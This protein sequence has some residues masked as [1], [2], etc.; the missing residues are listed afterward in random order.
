MRRLPHPRG[1]WIALTLSGAGR[2]KRR[3]L[4]IEMTEVEVA[5]RAGRH[6]VGH[7]GLVV[8]YPVI[9]WIEGGEARVARWRS[10]SGPPP[11]RVVI[12]DDTLSADSAYGLACQGSALLWRGDFQNARQMLAALARRTEPRG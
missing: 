10:P 5:E 4:A 6:T 2:V 11:A 3:A 8:A 12:A 9:H 1:S 7:N